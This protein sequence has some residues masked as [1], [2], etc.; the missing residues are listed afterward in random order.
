MTKSC[1]LKLSDIE[2]SIIEE[3]LDILYFNN[4]YFSLIQATS[5]NKECPIMLALKT[6]E[7]IPCVAFLTFL[8]NK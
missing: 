8:T 1:K 2:M 7:C 4:G 5:R 6:F 3:V